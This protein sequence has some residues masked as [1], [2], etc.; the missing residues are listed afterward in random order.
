MQGWWLG[1]YTLLHE[2]YV[3]VSRLKLQL[4]VR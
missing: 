2:R 1:G 4:A 3:M